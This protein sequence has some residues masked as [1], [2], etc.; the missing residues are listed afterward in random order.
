MNHP[1]ETAPGI[2]NGTRYLCPLCD[3]WLDVPP[4]PL[5]HQE[6]GSPYVVTVQNAAAIEGALAGHFATVQHRGMAYGWGPWTAETLAACT[7]GHLR[8][9]H[10]RHDGQCLH[11]T[12]TDTWAC[13]C[14]EFTRR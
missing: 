1:G 4:L 3:W 2:P 9:D 5:S 8:G 13:D 11:S 14:A 12:D 7:C 10:F 6:P